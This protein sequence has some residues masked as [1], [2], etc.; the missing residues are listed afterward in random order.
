MIGAFVAVSRRPLADG[1]F[2]G[3]GT[4]LYFRDSAIQL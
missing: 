1:G 3:C 2:W 4:P